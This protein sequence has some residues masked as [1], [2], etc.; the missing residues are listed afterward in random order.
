MT[1]PDHPSM[2]LDGAPS[3]VFVNSLATSSDMW[4]GVVAQ[5]PDGIRA[6]R[7]DQRDRAASDGR[8]S[9][10]TADQRVR[11]RHRATER[12]RIG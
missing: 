8:A 10:A 12:R 3:I 4:D 7:Y 6:I 11:H 2:D 5:L 1:H 9:T